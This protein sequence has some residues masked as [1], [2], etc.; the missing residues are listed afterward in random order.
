M[1]KLNNQVVKIAVTGPESTGKTELCRSLGSHYG[2]DY[3]PEYARGYVEGLKRDYTYEDVEHIAHAQKDELSK[4]L[5]QDNEIIIMDTYLV[6]T[7]IWFKEVF[8]RVPEW[9]DKEL[10][11]SKIDLFLVCYYDIP[12]E[13][14]PVRENPGPMRKYLFEKYI[15]EIEAIG[16]PFEIVKGMGSYRVQNA[17]EAVNRHFPKLKNG[18]L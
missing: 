5:K 9:I 15:Q 13:E 12:W 2:V 10:S 6:I 11:E 18:I 1:L 14:D 16:L 17:I 7:K 8:K 4:F 3:I